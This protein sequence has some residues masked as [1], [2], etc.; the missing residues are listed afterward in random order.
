MLLGAFGCFS[1]LY[2]IKNPFVW[3]RINIITDELG[4]RNE[5]EL[6]D[7]DYV[8]IGDSFIHSTNIT[9]KK[10][11]NYVLKDE[12]NINSYNAGMA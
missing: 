7:A 5:T 10:I 11:L 9:Q 8:L 3:K 2:L 4:F 1:E 6:D 12:F